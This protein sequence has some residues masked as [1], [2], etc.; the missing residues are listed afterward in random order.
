[1]VTFLI[2]VKTGDENRDTRCK[3]EMYNMA[4][5]FFWHCMFACAVLCSLLLVA[6]CSLSIRSLFCLVVIV[7][8]SSLIVIVMLFFLCSFPY[9][10]SVVGCCLRSFP[11][12]AFP[13]VFFWFGLFAIPFVSVFWVFSFIP[14]CC[15]L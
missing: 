1:M 14:S 8:V 15:V 10:L 5:I 9:F 11:F 13:H 7:C 4:Y 6:R 3:P 12:L 2:F